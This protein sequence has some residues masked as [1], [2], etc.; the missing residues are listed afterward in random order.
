[1]DTTEKLTLVEKIENKYRVFSTALSSLSA[2]TIA[3]MMLS[4]TIDATARYVLNKPLPGIFE[5]NEVLL[6]ICVY[7]GITWTQME[8]GHIRVEVII[9]RVSRNTRHILNILSW[10]VALIFVAILCYQTFQGF[11]DSFRIREFRWGS[12]QMP[13]WWA[14][15]LVPLGCLMLMAQ[16]VLDIWKEIMALSGFKKIEILE[17][18]P[19]DRLG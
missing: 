18:S 2:I 11:Q 8:R 9:S 1:M 10:A 7:M 5:L 12:V 17:G 13:I 19:S 14:K 15:G 6:V 16:L 4:T 3:I